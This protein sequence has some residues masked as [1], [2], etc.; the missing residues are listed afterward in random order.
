[1][2]II[3]C[4]MIVVFILNFSVTFLVELQNFPRNFMKFDLTRGLS[5][6]ARYRL[7]TPGNGLRGSHSDRFTIRARFA[8]S[9]CY[10]SRAKITCKFKF[11]ICIIVYQPFTPS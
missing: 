5:P 7:P 1:M 9:P 2:I 8:R 6:P 4:R 11:G 10:N 3:C